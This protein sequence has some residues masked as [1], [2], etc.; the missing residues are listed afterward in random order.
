MPAW[1]DEAPRLSGKEA[2]EQALRP[3]PIEYTYKN[4]VYVCVCGDGVAV[5]LGITK[6]LTRRM[7]EFESNSPFKFWYLR[8]W[9]C[10][11]GRAFSVER[12]LMNTYASARIH[13]E[14]YSPCESMATVTIPVDHE[15]FA[16]ADT[17]KGIRESGRLQRVAHSMW[18]S[19]VV[20]EK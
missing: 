10:G 14:W 2:Q 12:W 17:R 4:W 1:I 5:K 19:Q 6:D 8:A 16:D 18:P 20:D 9:C 3:W 15:H 11:R 7:R 13:G